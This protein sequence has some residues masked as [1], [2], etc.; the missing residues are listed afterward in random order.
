[1]TDPKKGKWL[2][3]MFK[4]RTPINFFWSVILFALLAVAISQLI[5]L[6]V[7]YV[8][9]AAIVFYIFKTFLNN[10]PL[11][12]TC[13]HCGKIILSNT[14]W[15]CGFKG[16]KNEQPNYFPF[17]Y[18]CEHCHAQPKAYRC[19]H[20]KCGKLI[21]LTEDHLTSN[22]A[23]C[24]NSPDEITEENRSKTVK[25][26][27]QQRQDTIHEIEMLELD[28]KLVKTLESMPDDKDK[29]PYKTLKR[30]TASR[31]KWKEAGARMRKEI[32]EKYK[33]DK[34]TRTRQLLTLEEVLKQRLTQE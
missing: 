4:L 29:S 18:E 12:I 2:R 9:S 16:C 24:L 11:R 17:L 6:L 1:M 23:F 32:S 30:E 27:E 25:Q 20:K 7:A 21:F 5:P 13:D 33:G 3:L 19:H 10:R 22:Y 15:V 28:K 14:P 31:L 26:R 8:I 34:A